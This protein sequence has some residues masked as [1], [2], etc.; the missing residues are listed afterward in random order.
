MAPTAT[1]H[2]TIHRLDKRLINQI[3]AGEVIVRPASAVKELIENSLDADA[4]RIEIAV[5][6]DARTFTVRDDG[7]GMSRE[8]AALAIERHTTSK[9]ECFEDLARLATRGFRGEALAAIASVSRFSLLTR[10]SDSLGAIELRAEGG[11]NTRLGEAGA[12]PGTMVSVRDLFYN[13]PARMKFLR[14]PVVEWGHIL[15]T[16]IRQSLARPDVAFV[17]RWRAKPY[18][19]LPAAQSLADRLAAVLPRESGAGLIEI[20]EQVHG[21]RAY[22]CIG[23]PQAT[24]RD[25]RH[26]YFFVNGRPIVSRPLTFALQEAYRGLIMTQQFPVAAVL[27]EIPGE[28]IDVNVHPTKEEVRFRNEP[29]AAGAVHRAA[30]QALR[31][32]DLVP[33]LDLPREPG[34]RLAPGSS[35]ASRIPPAARSGSRGGVFHPSTPST[36]PREAPPPGFFTPG[37][38]VGEAVPGANAEQLPL[39]SGKGEPTGYS[40]VADRSA[41][42]PERYSSAAESEEATLIAR[43]QAAEGPPNVLAQIELTYILA[44]APGLGLLLVDQHAVHEKILY[45]DFMRR[46]RATEVQTLLAPYTFEASPTE[47]AAM[48]LLAPALTA[49]GF[50]TTHFGGST[51]LIETVPLVFDKIDACAFVRDLLDELGGADLKAGLEL[52][53]HRIGARAACRAAVKAGDPLNRAEMQEL[54][55]EVLRTPEAHRCPHGRPTLVLL[56]KDHLDRRFGRT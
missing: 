24:R 19:N 38:P 10:A 50:Q 26:Q 36:D 8:D 43:L 55:D 11:S 14:T 51:W 39:D 45:L 15:K 53:R 30:L 7:R 44:E 13:L 6:E 33:R 41:A 29:L 35:N 32:A 2:P 9:L 18:L 54:L 46:E 21:V 4:T 17:I 49:E 37:A 23:A 28:E 40:P 47:A 20:D 5:E 22:G 42:A 31:A 25:R 27:L 56:S 1:T 34:A 52:E 16:F 12:P 3:A 48:E